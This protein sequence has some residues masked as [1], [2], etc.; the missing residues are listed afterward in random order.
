MLVNLGDL[1]ADTSVNLW[2][3]RKKLTATTSRIF[4]SEN[5]D[6]SILWE[7]L[8]PGSKEDS[9]LNPVVYRPVHIGQIRRRGFESSM[10]TGC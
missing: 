5:E 7:N 4:S 6:T 1:Y 3:V 9:E 8:C 2:S 10:G